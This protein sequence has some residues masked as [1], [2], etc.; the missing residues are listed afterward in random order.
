MFPA[1]DGHGPIHDGGR[2]EEYRCVY[3]P[4]QPDLQQAAA[5]R[6]S[7]PSVV[8][9]QSVGS[10]RRVQERVHRVNSRRVDDRQPGRRRTERCVFYLEYPMQP[11]QSPQ[12]GHGVGRVKHIGGIYLVAGTIT[13]DVS[14]RY[15]RANY[16]ITTAQ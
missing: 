2:D 3:V 6:E 4:D 14:T 11:G 1:I 9:R 5:L 8:R 10:A 16:D 13:D 12:R 15:A 7:C